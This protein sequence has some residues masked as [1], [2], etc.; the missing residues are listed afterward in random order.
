MS[1]VFKSQTHM[2]Q[3]Q[4][5]AIPDNYVAI[6]KTIEKGSALA[7]EEDGRK[8]VKAGTIYPANTASAQG[9]ILNDYDVT[10]GDAVVALVIFG[11][12]RTSKLPAKPTEEAKTAMKLVAFLGE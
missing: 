5:L 6:A 9:V 3:K 11:F 8:I 12:V 7:V 1:V 2:T 10:D 4:I